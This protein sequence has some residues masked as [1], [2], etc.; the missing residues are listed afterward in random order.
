MPDSTGKLTS[1]EVQKAIDWLKKHSKSPCAV[2]GS[3]RWDV[4][5]HLVQPITL[6]KDGEMLLGGVGYP[7]FIATCLICGNTLFFNAVFAGLVPPDQA[8]K[9]D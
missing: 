7:Q 9:K 8:K 2:C 3:R 5:Q 4:A 1:K 6:G